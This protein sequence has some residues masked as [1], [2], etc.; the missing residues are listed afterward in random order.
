MSVK[1]APSLLA[2]DFANL[3]QE[4]QIIEK[5]GADWLHI[6]VMDGH[7]VPNISFGTVVIDAL[8]ADSNL[9]FD[10]HLMISE[11]DRYI[12]D[13]VKS[14]ADLISV[15]QEACPHLHRT[16][17]SIKQQG[18]KAGV[19]LNPA[20]PVSSIVPILSDVDLVLLMSVN[21]GFGG[22]R[23]I[24]EILPKVAELKAILQE[25]GLHEVEIEVDGGVNQENATSLIE[26]GVTVLVAG[27]SVFGKE[28]RAQAIAG[29]RGE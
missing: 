14:G 3:K 2:A 6:D 8:R 13:F 25:K 26:Q 20:T 18:V 24:A 23:F 27:S 29:L 7:F 11:P 16:I 1:I 10:V 4:L 15:H 5:A 12:G 19:V 28:N 22:Q 17:H 9:F 21:P